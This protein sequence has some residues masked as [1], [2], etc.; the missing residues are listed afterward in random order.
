MAFGYVGLRGADFVMTSLL[1]LAH[2]STQDAHILKRQRGREAIYCVS[3]MKKQT[4][5]SEGIRRVERIKRMKTLTVLVF[6]VGK[7]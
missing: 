3:N 1:R 4:D 6:V 5:I 7:V 2:S